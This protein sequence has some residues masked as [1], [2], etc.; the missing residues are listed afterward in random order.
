MR[1]QRRVIAGSAMALALGIGVAGCGPAANPSAA[2]LATV[3]GQ[4]ITNAAWQQTVDG[5]GLLSG[6]KLPTDKADKKSQVEQLMVW[7][8]VEQWT[9]GH[10]L[11][12]RQKAAKEAQGLVTELESA[13]GGKTGLIAQLKSYGLTLTQFQSFLTDQQILQTAFN[14]ETAH[15][16]PPSAAVVKQ[17]YQQNASLFAQPQSDQVRIILVKTKTLATQLEARLQ[18][19]ASFAALA[20]QY[21]LD[22][23]S[24]KNGG[25]VGS[26]PISTSSGLPTGFLSVLSGLKTGQYGIAGTS[27]GYYVIQVEKI[28]PP[29][30]QPL[31]AVQSS[32]VSQLEASAKNQAFQTWGAKVEH[33]MKTHLY[34][35]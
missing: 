32:I 18:H 16:A 12:T 22:K 17:Y 11:I 20:T 15:V 19:G 6:Q 28:T 25:Q 21:S 9:L 4:A 2:V 31:S 30:E 27:S 24:A 5:L 13:S 3:N 33:Q 10:H 23:T 14:K 1:A 7:S 8:A 34:L 26:V 29:S 35:P